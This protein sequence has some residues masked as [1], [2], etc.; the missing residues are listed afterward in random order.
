LVEKVPK[1][2]FNFLNK[3]DELRRPISARYRR[4]DPF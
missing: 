2:K 3:M 4:P 1:L